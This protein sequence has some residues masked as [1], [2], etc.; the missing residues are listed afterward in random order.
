MLQRLAFPLQRVPSSLE[1]FLNTL[2]E[3]VFSRGYRRGF[4]GAGIDE[5][6]A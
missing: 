2:P 3:M 6:P 5:A 4:A 1:A